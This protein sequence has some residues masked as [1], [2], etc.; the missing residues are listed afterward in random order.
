MMGV[1]FGVGFELGK[2]PWAKGS[3]VDLTILGTA[4]T[5]ELGA[6]FTSAESLN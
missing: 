2:T 1:V 4:D 6:P 5:F 3:E